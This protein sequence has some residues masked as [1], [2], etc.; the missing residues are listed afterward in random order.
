VAGV[1]LRGW[2]LVT[3]G[4][5]FTVIVQ[6]SPDRSVVSSGPYRFVRHPGYAGV[7]LA[8]IGVGLMSGNW[9]GAAAMTFLSLIAVGRRIRIEESAL[10]ATLD[11]RYRAYAAAHKRLMPLVW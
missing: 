9:V 11:G 8:T 1:I 3:L 10:I 7:M 6:V 4:Q 2:A 5:Y